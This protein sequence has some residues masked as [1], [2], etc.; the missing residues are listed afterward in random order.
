MTTSASAEITRVAPKG[1]T[2]QPEPAR[3]WRWRGQ[4]LNGRNN[5]LNLVRLVLAFSV[6][7]FHSWPLG[8]FVGSPA[9]AGVPL[10]AWAVDAFFCISGY[11]ITGSRLAKPLGTYLVHRAARIYPAFWVC[12]LVIVAFFAP[13]D[14]ARTHG[15]LDGYLTAPGVTPINFLILNATLRIGSYG[16]SDTLAT[17]PYPVAW[18][19]SVW[20][21][22]YEFICY[23]V[24]AG[25]AAFAWWRRSAWVS[26]VAFAVSVVAAANA[27]LL[28][29]YIGSNADAL[30]VL[31]LLPFFLGGACVQMLRHRLP[32]HW[33][34]AVVAFLG[35]AACL[36]ISPVWGPPLAGAF[37]TYLLLWLGSAIPSPKLIHRHDISYGVYIYAFPVQQSLAAFGVNHHGVIIFALAATVLTV[38]FAAAS[39]LLIERPVMRRARQSERTAASPMLAVPTDPVLVL[40]TAPMRA[41]V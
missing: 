23:L 5:S 6:L 26:V 32:L 21:L 19:G 7:Y 14:Y 36:S 17:A 40:P 24:I 9:I 31:G 1:V 10:G 12:M 37:L 38:P 41:T 28:A 13:V 4:Q 8:G 30:T 15:S 11:L 39:W 35:I 33:S 29:P 20:S 27:P 22:Y 34:G 18:D 16:I 3:L 25:L 2:A